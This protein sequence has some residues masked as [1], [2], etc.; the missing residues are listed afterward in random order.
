MSGDF[1]RRRQAIPGDSGLV[2]YNRNLP[3]RETVKQRGFPHIRAT[4]NSNSGHA[5][6]YDVKNV[7]HQARKNVFCRFHEET[8]GFRPI[9]L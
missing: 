2:M 6:E 4:N 1:T 9:A 7:N 3:S 8:I 5:D